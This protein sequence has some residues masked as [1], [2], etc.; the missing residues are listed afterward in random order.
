MS[1]FLKKVT[2]SARKT[3]HAVGFV[4]GLKNT[5]STPSVSVTISVR[6]TSSHSATTPIRNEYEDDEVASE[7]P[8]P[9]AVRSLSVTA[10]IFEARKKAI[11]YVNADTEERKK[12]VECVNVEME[13]R[14]RIVQLEIVRF[15]RA[16]E[17]ANSDM[18]EH[19]K[20]VQY[21]IARVKERERAARRVF[22]SAEAFKRAVNRVIVRID[23]RKEELARAYDTIKKYE[24][25]IKRIGADIKERKCAVKERECAVKKREEAAHNAMATIKGYTT[26]KQATSLG[27]ALKTHMEAS[28]LSPSAVVA[29][30]KI[31]KS[32]EFAVGKVESHEET[33]DAVEEIEVLGNTI[34]FAKRLLEAL[35][36][37]SHA[38]AVGRKLNKRKETATK[39]EAAI[40]AEALLFLACAVTFVDTK[41]ENVVNGMAFGDRAL[42][43][44]KTD[45]ARSERYLDV[46]SRPCHY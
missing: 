12:E 45:I 4:L 21:E 32:F 3:G 30:S 9:V 15:E 6:Q 19:K 33:G 10:A 42:K 41:L 8:E 14:E 23:E 37:I 20:A 7:W 29:A 26:I 13:E 28:M 31:I 5:F 2:R 24:D 35:R 36:A 18:E 43:N 17:R 46:I 44:L 38:Q 22:V 27:K 40:A 25:N 39:F 34:I 1:S 16:I 11:E